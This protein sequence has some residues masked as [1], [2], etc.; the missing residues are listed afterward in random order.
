MNLPLTILL[1]T[2]A[3]VIS[4]RSAIAN[5]AKDRLQ[6]FIIPKILSRYLSVFLQTYYK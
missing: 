6:Y 2:S 5:A 3:G 1:A 4:A